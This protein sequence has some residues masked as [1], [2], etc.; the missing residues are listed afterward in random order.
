MPC[1]FYHCVPP[2][3]PIDLGVLQLLNTLFQHRL[4]VFYHLNF[5][6]SSVIC[7]ERHKSSSLLPPRPHPYRLIVVVVVYHFHVEILFFTKRVVFSISFCKYDINH[8]PYCVGE[9][10]FPLLSPSFCPRAPYIAWMAPRHLLPPG[11]HY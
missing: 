8:H 7:E 3:A 9:L 5:L 6:H 11:D 10:S 1:F 2:P 4:I